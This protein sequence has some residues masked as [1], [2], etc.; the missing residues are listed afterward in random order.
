MKEMDGSATQARPKPTK[1]EEM[2]TQKGNAT[3][4]SGGER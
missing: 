2:E 4:K 1:A 3:K